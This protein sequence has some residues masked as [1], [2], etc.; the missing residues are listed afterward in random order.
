MWLPGYTTLGGCG[1]H[2]LVTGAMRDGTA[3]TARTPET[4]GHQVKNQDNQ[5]QRTSATRAEKF[6]Q[7]YKIVGQKPNRDATKPSSVPLPR[8]PAQTP[9]LSK[10][11][12][13]LRFS[14]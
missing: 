10:G 1:Q 9:L 2:V 5:I 8:T 11:N 4:A 6:N 13:K 7:K 3:A 14:P 12:A